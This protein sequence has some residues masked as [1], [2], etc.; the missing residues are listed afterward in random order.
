MENKHERKINDEEADGFKTAM[1]RAENL[2]KSGLRVIYRSR[3]ML[4]LK[5][6]KR[7]LSE[8]QFAQVWLALRRVLCEG[9]VIVGEEGE[10]AARRFQDL[11]SNVIQLLR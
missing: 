3:A 7:T 1:I 11:K 6:L 9:M 8:A 5:E 4:H 2:R 10:I